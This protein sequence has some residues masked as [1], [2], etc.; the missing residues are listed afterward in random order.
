MQATIGS[1]FQ[2]TIPA[3]LRKKLRLKPGMKLLFDEHASNLRRK[4]V[5]DFD[6]VAM[7]GAFGAAKN[8]E[9]TKTS[10]QILRELRGYS[11]RAL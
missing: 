2:I 6:I 8:F 11:R 7:R 4:P 1:K 9:P 10:I 5:Y 3:K